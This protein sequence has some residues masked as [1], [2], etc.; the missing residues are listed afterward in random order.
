MPILAPQPPARL[1]NALARVN[2]RRRRQRRGRRISA[3]LWRSSP[4]PDAGQSAH[5]DRPAIALWNFTKSAST[6]I[7]TPEDG[8]RLPVDLVHVC[9]GQSVCRAASGPSHE[10]DQLV[11]GAGCVEVF[12]ALTQ[13]PESRER[14]ALPVLPIFDLVSR[15]RV[16]PDDGRI[17]AYGAGLIAAGHR[18]PAKFGVFVPWQVIVV[19]VARHGTN[20]VGRCPHNSRSFISSLP[21]D[22]SDDESLA[23]SR[24]G[25]RRLASPGL[26]GL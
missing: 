19:I 10:P 6:E 25:P 7:R 3:V 9:L 5:R 20:P 16:K 24:M 4:S 1:A 26:P 17:V 18:Q 13:R 21:H 22:L 8:Q 2:G 12:A 23:H 15:E 11:I 14:V